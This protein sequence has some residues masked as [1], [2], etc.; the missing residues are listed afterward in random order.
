MENEWGVFLW[1]FHEIYFKTEALKIFDNPKDAEWYASHYGEGC[2]PGGHV[3]KI[4]IDN[5]A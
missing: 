1:N 3:V 4:I 2:Y 5:C